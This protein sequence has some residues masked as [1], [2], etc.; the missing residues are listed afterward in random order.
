[1]QVPKDGF[2]PGE[3]D[4]YFS[5]QKQHLGPGQQRVWHGMCGRDSASDRARFM[6]ALKPGSAQVRVPVC[7]FRACHTRVRG[8]VNA[9]GMMDDWIDSD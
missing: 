7:P 4:L 1:M 5:G 2:L 6:S 9:R 3:L 8:N